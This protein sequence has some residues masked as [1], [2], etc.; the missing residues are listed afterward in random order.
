[1]ACT[2]SNGLDQLQREDSLMRVEVCSYWS[3]PGVFSLGVALPLRGW[4]TF[5]QG[6]PKIIA[7][8][9]GKKV[10]RGKCERVLGKI[11]QTSR[12]PIWLRNTKRLQR[13]KCK[14]NKWKMVEVLPLAWFSRLLLSLFLAFVCLL[15]QPHPSPSVLQLFCFQWV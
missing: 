3:R 11:Q 10:L 15:A 6:S 8:H 14:T 13:L 12:A 4:V 9:Q 5:S 7:K 2:F 1:M